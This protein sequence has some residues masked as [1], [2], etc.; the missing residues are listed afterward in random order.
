[1]VLAVRCG[2]R[3]RWQRLHDGRALDGSPRLVP[4]ASSSTAPSRRSRRSSSRTRA[5]RRTSATAARALGWPRPPSGCG[6]PDLSRC[7]RR[8]ARTRASSRVR[9]SGYL[10]Q[11]VGRDAAGKLRD[12]HQRPD[13]ERP[14][15]AVDERAAGDPASGSRP[16]RPSGSVGDA[17]HG[18]SDGIGKLLDACLPPAGPITIEPLSRPRPTRACN[19]PCRRT[20]CP[21]GTG[22][23]SASPPTT[24]SRT[25]CRRRTGPGARRVLHGRQPAPSGPAEPPLRDDALRPRR[26]VGARSVV[27]RVDL[28]GQRA[29][30]RDLRNRPISRRAATGSARARS[31]T[32]SRA[33]ASVRRRGAVDV[34][35]GGIAGAQTPQQYVE[36]RDGVYREIPIRGIVLLGTRTPST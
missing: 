12:H 7:R 4:R 15:A 33:S 17:E 35:S 13:A 34:A 26:V 27:R 2:L 16:V 3:R 28:P 8:A 32:A 25:S 11:A 31:G 14:R 6:L 22:S 21:R 24:T 1:M 5:A 18:T 10:F 20:S 30:R 19:S 9:P 29:R 23:R 36:P